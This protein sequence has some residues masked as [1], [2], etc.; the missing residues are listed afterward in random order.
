MHAPPY[1]PQAEKEAL[2]TAINRL[3]EQEDLWQRVHAVLA[4]SDAIE[5]AENVLAVLETQ[6]ETAEIGF[7]I[8]VD[9]LRTLLLMAREELAKAE[10]VTL[11]ALGK[12][13]EDETSQRT[14]L[15]TVFPAGTILSCPACGEGLYKV[16]QRAT[17]EDLVL[18]EGTFLAPLNRTIPPR[19]VWTPLACPLCGG[20]LLK[21]GRIHTL[22]RAWV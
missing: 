2:Y 8:H 19:E 15:A 11:T 18:D 17:M 3:H 10:R 4:L 20:R 1:D 6:Q 14:A 7:Q 5:H 13:Q 16:T 9:G 21:D 12:R 22:Q